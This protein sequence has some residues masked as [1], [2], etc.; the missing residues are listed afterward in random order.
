MTQPIIDYEEDD[1]VKFICS[2]KPSPFFDFREFSDRYRPRNNKNTRFTSTFREQ[3][4][5]IP[6]VN[7]SFPSFEYVNDSLL[8]CKVKIQGIIKVRKC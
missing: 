8:G 7:T 4:F 6:K 1:D 2:Y 5:T 3:P